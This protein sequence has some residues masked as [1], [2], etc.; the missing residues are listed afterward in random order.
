MLTRA[1]GTSTSCDA[2]RRA[3]DLAR[4]GSR[5]PTPEPSAFARLW[6]EDLQRLA[7]GARESAGSSP[8]PSNSAAR[9][10]GL[11][12]ARRPARRGRR[13]AQEL[14]DRGGD[15][16]GLLGRGA[17]ARELDPRPAAGDCLPLRLTAGR[18]SSRRRARASRSSTTTPCSPRSRRRR[19]SSACAT[20]SSATPRRVGDAAEGLPRR[21]AA[22]RLPRDAGA[23]RRARDPQ[24]DHVVPGQPGARA[25]DRDRGDLRLER[26]DRRAARADRRAAR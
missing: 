9:S 12:A 4:G 10:H 6:P 3:L 25:A 20:G 23:R 19:R 11:I 26:R 15:R 2:R 8:A 21:A 17:P 24:V 13:V 1:C 7:P 5:E 22:R 16:G 14:L 18:V